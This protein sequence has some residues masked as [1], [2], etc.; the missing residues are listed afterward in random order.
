[1]EQGRLGASMLGNRLILAGCARHASNP[2]EGLVHPQMAANGEP[3]AAPMCMVTLSPVTIACACEM[4]PAVC[5][6]FQIP[7]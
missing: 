4:A 5:D 1:M 6:R 3:V 7:A 2:S